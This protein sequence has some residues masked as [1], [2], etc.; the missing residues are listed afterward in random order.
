[1]DWTQVDNYCERLGP[2]FWAEPLNAA[3]N[4]AFV[5]AALVVWAILGGKRDPGARVLA[6]ILFA[7]GVGSFLFHTYATRWAGLAD[8]LPILLFI[9][10]YVYLATRRFLGAGVILS[11]AAVLLF[12]PFSWAVTQGIGSITGPLN[13]SLSYLP[14]PILILVYA[15]V[16]WRAAPLT[17]RGLAIGAGILILSLFF[18]TVDAAVCGVLPI[19]THFLWHSLNALMLGWMI[20]VLH[21]HL[22]AERRAG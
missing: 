2:G 19:G 22:P 11:G 20:L 9:L 8:V 18:R 5:I 12:F 21:T 16:V 17:A 6:A 14:V 15:A 4:A 3:T 1:M 13:G 7:I 10:A